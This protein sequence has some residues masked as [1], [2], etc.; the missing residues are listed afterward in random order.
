[1]NK[2]ID[3]I[4][5][6]EK[7]E[8]QCV[9]IKSM[10]QSTR[11]EDHMKTIVIDQ[12]LCTSSS[13]EHKCMNNI[14]KIYQH[15]GNFDDQQNLKDILDVAMVLTPEGFIYNSPNVSMT[16]TPVKKPSARKSLCIF[17]NIFN[18]KRKT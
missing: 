12:S 13:F 9:V 10:L 1:M 3:S 5:P 7:F 16:S 17:T 14:E 2:A 6:I 8:Q 15:A 4:L 11:I 18:V